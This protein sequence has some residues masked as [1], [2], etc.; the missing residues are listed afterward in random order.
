MKCI[1]C[2]QAN[3]DV[4]ETRTSEDS[5]AIR[6]RRHCPDCGKRFTTY[7]RTES[8]PFI[9]IKRDGR[10]ERFS[11]E[12]LVQGILKAVEKTQVPYAQ[13]EKIA[14]EVESELRNMN[15]TEV[16]SMILGNLVA[17]SLKKIDKV[18]YI[19]FAS[20]FRRFVDVDDFKKELQNIL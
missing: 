13:V 20:V 10:R 3:T 15:E 9:V 14:D 17:D 12:K 2:F 19:R 4:V 7:E 11:R 8:L 16:E 5:L 1:F 6:R 18:A